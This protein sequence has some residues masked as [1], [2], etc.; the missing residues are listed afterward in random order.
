MR[1]RS[2]VAIL[3]MLCAL[4]VSAAIAQSAGA[5]GTTAYLCK[6]P[7]KGD[8]AVGPKFSDSRCT[9]VDEGKG[10][11]RHVK[12]SKESVAVNLTEAEPLFM[13]VD[14]AGVTVEIRAKKWSA[15]GTFEND[16]NGGGEMF[17]GGSTSKVI[18]EEVT[19][20]N[21]TCEISG[22]PGG[23]GK[24]ETA[25]IKATTVGQGDSVIFE[26]KTGTKLAEFELLGASCPAALKGKYP[27]VGSV[28]PSE[29]E[30]STARFT[31]GATTAEK[32]LRLQS[33]TGPVVGLFCTRFM[34]STAGG[35]LPIS[36]TT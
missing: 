14:L 22:I 28:K 25:A 6:V 12:I 10:T 36:P 35:L 16:E 26:P 27:V 19:V 29:I 3:S 7:S 21:K 15:S 1:N 24:I 32:T 2:A 23:T 4:T 8:E 18:F 31:Y 13:D 17:I 20:L 9:A 30:G 5:A 11:V 33:A 34:I